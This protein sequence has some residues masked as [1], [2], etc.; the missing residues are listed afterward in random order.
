VK[1]LWVDD[2]P[3]NNEVEIE[4]IKARLHGIGAEFV[5]SEQ[6]PDALE[7]LRSGLYNVVITNYGDGRCGGKA[8]AECVLEGV[9]QLS[10]KP[11]VIIYSM[12]VRPEM[13]AEM[14]CKGAIADTQE[15]NILFAWIVRGLAADFAFEPS[16]QVK[17]FC[18]EQKKREARQ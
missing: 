2:Q 9:E 1:I 10:K 14:K 13:A 4:D 12:N 11:P 3:K 17:K 18:T 15:P 5:Q 7:R 8:I 16:P 6:V